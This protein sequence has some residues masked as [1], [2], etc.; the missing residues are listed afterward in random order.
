MVRGGN[1]ACTTKIPPSTN[2]FQPLMIP[3]PSPIAN[4]LDRTNNENVEC[5]SNN[6]SNVVR[7][8]VITTNDK[9]GSI[10]IS[11]K[12][13]HQ[14][15]ARTIKIGIQRMRRNCL[16][17][18]PLVLAGWSRRWT[19]WSG[20]VGG[21]AAA[22]G[23]GGI[24][25]AN[26]ATTVLPKIYA[27]GGSS[28]AVVMAISGGAS[29]SA[30]AAAAATVYSD[31]WLLPALVCATAYA[32][33]NLFIKK[34]SSS[35]SAPIDPILGGVLLQLVAAMMGASLYVWKRLT[36]S[37]GGGGGGTTTVLPNFFS[38]SILKNGGVGW[39]VAAGVA[40]GAAEILSFLISGM[41][42]PASKSIPT[43]VGGSVV[44]GTLVGSVWLKEKLSLGGWIGVLLIAIGIALVGM[45]P[46][47]AGGH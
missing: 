37:G 3:P 25:A 11:N 6:N 20:G 24:A 34:A 18:L 45:D 14:F 42:V 35:T 26:T 9:C 40:V 43:V 12:D 28:L 39:S 22:A 17:I 29:S 16:A 38:K 46:S 23:V 32:F 33:Y 10:S 21:I 4:K 13:R 2:I 1:T 44:V 7:Q 31:L 47:S 30:A 8:S 19:N 27:N 15:V 41:G 36:S 5:N